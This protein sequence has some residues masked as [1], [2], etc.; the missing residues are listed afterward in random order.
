[1]QY[2]S[3]Q[4]NFFRICY[5][6]FKLVPEGLRQI[7][8]QEWNF[9]YKVTSGGEWQDTTQNGDDFVRKEGKKSQAKNKRYLATIQNGNTA[10][11]DCSCLSFAILFSDSIGTTLSS[12]IENGVNDLRQ[13]RNDIA[14]NCEAKLTDAEFQVYIV[15]ILHSFTSLGLPVKDI[16]DVRKQTSFPT[17]ELQNLD[18][19]VDSL[20]REL[21]RKGDDLQ[22]T[23]TKLQCKDE[24]VTALTQEIESKVKS[25]CILP[26]EPAHEVIRR[27]NDI[28]RLKKKMK[29]LEEGS[30]QAVSTIYIS[31]TPGSGK[32]QLARQLGQEFFCTRSRDTDDLVFV[33]TLNAQSVEALA[34]S[35]MT[36]GKYLGIS[37]HSLTSLENNKRENPRETIKHLKV[38]IPT[39]IRKFSKWLLIADNVVELKAIRSFLPRITITEWG[40]GQVLITTQDSSTIPCNAPHTYHESLSK[41]M[42]REDAVEVLKQVSQISNEAEQVEK[43]AKVLEY[44]PLALAAAA[45]YVNTVVTN[46]SPDYSWA[47]YME[48]LCTGQREATEE[49]L[50]SENSAYPKTMTT[51]IQIA[52]ERAFQSDEVL[53]QAFSFLSLC[54]SDLLPVEAVVNF[55]KARIQSGLPKELIKAKILKSCLILSSPVDQQGPECL[56]LHNTVHE[57]LKQGMISKLEPAEK[58]QNLATAIK[59]L[60]PLLESEEKEFK[61]TRYGC[62]MLNKMT[63]HCKALLESATCDFTCPERDLLNELTSV[64]S[65]GDV[66]KWLCSTARSCNR[67]DDLASANRISELA[68]NLLLKNASDTLEGTWL[69]EIAFLTRG[70]AYNNAGKHQDAKEQYDKVLKIR[71]STYG[72]WHPKTAHIYQQLGFVCFLTGQY[73]QAEDFYKKALDIHTSN[74]GQDNSAVASLYHHLGVVYDT[75]EKYEEAKALLEKALAINKMIHG[76]EHADVA[77]SYSRLGALYHSM[78]EF[79]EAKQLHDMALVIRRKVYGELHSATAE[80]Y[81]QL[82]AISCSIGQFNTSIDLY[83]KALLIRRNMYGEAHGEVGATFNNLGNVYLNNGELEQAKEHFEKAL[84]I[85]KITLGEDH[86]DIVAV[87]VNLGLVYRCMKQHNVAEEYLEKALMIQR[88]TELGEKNERTAQ[89]Y[90]YLATVHNSTE[91]VHKA[92]KCYEIAMDIAKETCGE[93]HPLVAEIHHDLERLYQ[94]TGKKASER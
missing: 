81:S 7:F 44:Q 90:R 14:H 74:C 62:L 75:T 24:E 22:N 27:S 68:C 5:V 46:G 23:Q 63:S 66:V 35:Y 78:G 93:K 25:F 32:S 82:G 41:G 47:R 36:L 9:R 29:D 6:G 13:V 17:A 91:E 85:V 40:H 4:L 86:P 57:V 10:E 18:S 48:V 39:K 2:T 42:E 11:W 21:K 26:C 3:E 88:R 84:T 12:A 67:L 55:V 16:E 51:A 70:D 34:D 58:N 73:N 43:V 53:R 1:M 87:Y 8:K 20:K 60:V 15:R 50:A 45:F 71:V 38:L 19:L 79:K 69:H 59:I 65:L 76:E 72:K 31:G 64:V 77:E 52:L 56:R 33:A 37:E 28:T 83:K 61:T 94:R 92:K 89:I 54:S 80:N 49:V 30:H